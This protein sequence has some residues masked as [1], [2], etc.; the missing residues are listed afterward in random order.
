MPSNSDMEILDRPEDPLK[1]DNNHIKIWILPVVA[2]VLTLLWGIFTRVMV[3]LEHEQ[4]FD[5][6]TI[7][8]VPAESPYS[9][10]TDSR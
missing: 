6:G 10:G 7:P 5:F 2:L 3:G 9:T 8:F 4:D 1:A